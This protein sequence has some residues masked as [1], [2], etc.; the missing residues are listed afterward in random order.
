MRSGIYLITSPSG[1]RY[2]GSAVDWVSRVGTHRHRLRKGTHN[3]PKLLAA[4]KKYNGEGFV[5]EQIL[6]CRR[7]FLVE[8]EQH[9]I[10][11]LKPEI[12][13][14][15]FAN[16]RLGMRHT[17]EAKAKMSA[18][19]KGRKLSEETRKKLSIAS[20]LK[21]HSPE[22]LER[23][24]DGRRKLSGEALESYRASL[25]NAIAKRS[26]EAIQRAADHARSIGVRNKGKK[27]T[28]ATKANL[29]AGQRKRYER[30]G[31][32][33]MRT[34]DKLRRGWGDKHMAM[35]EWILAI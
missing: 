31:G 33:S 21:R 19:R 8:M 25:A 9:L 23:M 10:D 13:I 12:N 4:W 26:P 17:P 20:S 32:L 14:N 28:D 35:L 1:K 2:V 5:F 30:D 16:S 24:R 34:K 7:E 22:V 27:R 15:K 6:C 29:A 11:T 18:A 3:N